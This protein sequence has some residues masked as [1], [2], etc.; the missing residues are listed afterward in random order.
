MAIFH[1]HYPRSIVDTY[2]DTE[3]L[4][5]VEAI[6]HIEKLSKKRIKFPPIKRLTGDVEEFIESLPFKLT[7]DQSRAIS[8]I[9]RDFKSDI[10]TRRLVIG[11]VG[12]GKTI[13]ILACAVMSYP[14]RS[15]LMAP[16]SILAVQLY[17]EAIKFLPKHIKVSLV[18]Q[19]SG[20][21]ALDADFLIG[22]H[23]LLY[24][25]N[26]PE[27]PL[28]MIDE[29]HRFGTKQRTMLEKLVSSGER[30]PH[31]LQFSAT[32]IPRTIL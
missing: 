18:K 19:G 6:N 5:R 11:D 23:A 21:E 4:K 20:D 14:D 27:A 2:V 17:H 22:T 10:A 16:T 8:E 9:E 32:P 30:R 26:L 29:Q 13:I 25:D 31:F 24:K 1:L 28:I 15:I 12:S 3:L 7:D